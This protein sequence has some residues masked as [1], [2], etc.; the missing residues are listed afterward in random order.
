M[1][2]R[3]VT[4]LE[5]ASAYLLWLTALHAGLSGMGLEPA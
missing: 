5:L 1:F 2:N 4:P 3:S